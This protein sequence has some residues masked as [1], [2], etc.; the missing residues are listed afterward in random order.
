MSCD[1]NTLVIG[2]AGPQGPQ[3][4]NGI[5]G[6]NG[7]NGVNAFSTL[8]ATFTQPN[9]APAAGNTVTI[10]VSSTNWIAVGQ[11]LFIEQAGYYAVTAV[12]SSTSLT[13]S[14][15]VTAGIS[16]GASV[17]S[18]RKV[19]PGG[20]TSA[21]NTSGI[22]NSVVVNSAF[23]SN[24]SVFQVYGSSGF[25]LFLVNATLNKVGLN[26][27]PIST[28]ST[29]T[30]GGSFESSGNIISSGV[31]Q[32]PRFRLSSAGPELS[33]VLSYSTTLTVTLAGTVGAV[34][35]VDATVTGTAVGDI[36]QIAYTSDP[37]GT[38][39]IDV[40]ATCMVTGTNTVSVTFTNSSTN[41]YAAVSVPL[42]FIVSTY[43]AV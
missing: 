12:N 32:A 26:V 1:C 35:R 15:Q 39:E 40:V 31:V 17:S 8:T 42:K 38:F 19:S 2:E 33:K 24:P 34:T 3:G 13:V 21:L 27:T 7:S 28:S 10:S 18:G 20:P 30:V 14:L 36:A 22:F 9:V 37:G 5:D 16:A 4:F 29:F 11:S 23:A 6:T 25:P 41:A 43:S